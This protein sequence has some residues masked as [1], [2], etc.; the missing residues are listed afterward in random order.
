[1]CSAPGGT[2]ASRLAH[3]GAN[4]R[5]VPSETVASRLAQASRDPWTTTRNQPPPQYRLPQF[6]LSSRQQSI[7]S[8]HAQFVLPVSHHCRPSQSFGQHSQA[9]NHPTMNF[10]HLSQVFNHHSQPFNLQSQTFNHQ[11]PRD[12]LCKQKCAFNHHYQTSYH[13]NQPHDLFYSMSNNYSEAKP[14]MSNSQSCYGYMLSA[15]RGQQHQLAYVNRHA[16]EEHYT[17]HHNKLNRN[18]LDEYLNDHNYEHSLC[19]NRDMY[20]NHALTTT[21]PLCNNVYIERDFTN[22]G[23]NVCQ[24]E[25]RMRSH[26]ECCSLCCRGRSWTSTLRSPSYQNACQIDRQLQT[27]SRQRFTWTGTETSGASSDSDMDTR[28]HRNHSFSDDDRGGHVTNACSGHKMASSSLCQ[29][30]S[31]SSVTDASNHSTFG[32][33]DLPSEVSSYH[34]NV[35]C[36]TV[37]SSP[38]L[39]C[40]ER[41][42]TDSPCVFCSQR[43]PPAVHLRPSCL[44]ERCTS[45]QHKDCIIHHHPTSSLKDSSVRRP[46]CSEHRCFR[47]TERVSL[48][49]LEHHTEQDNYTCSLH[50]SS[51]SRQEE[52]PVPHSSRLRRTENTIGQYC[53]S[54]QGGCTLVGNFNQESVSLQENASSCESVNGLF[55]NEATCATVKGQLGNVHHISCRGELV[56]N[57]SKDDIVAHKRSSSSL[58]SA[59]NSGISALVSNLESVCGDSQSSCNSSYREDFCYANSNLLKCTC[60]NRDHT[61]DGSYQQNNP[62]L[63]YNIPSCHHRFILN[64]KNVELIKSNTSS[65][66]MNTLT[67]AIGVTE[68]LPVVNRGNEVNQQP[69]TKI[70]VKN[71]VNLHPFSY[72]PQRADRTDVVNSPPLTDHHDVRTSQTVVTHDASEQTFTCR[73]CQK[74][75]DKAET[76]MRSVVIYNEPD[77]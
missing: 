27:N 70:P 37:V 15:T 22:C 56:K 49:D 45:R 2:V 32:S 47:S 24:P 6:Q 14:R 12:L 65:S 8:A 3:A 19:I 4:P 9:V 50:L 13:D 23:R 69:F 43:E 76:C 18:A 11:L 52:N 68:H 53:D 28:K 57:P 16:L 33:S 41:Q 55:C 35:Y 73:S 59:R 31:D 30:G 21:S 1:M 7:R 51:N 60:R 67:P 10:N 64:D 20:V 74:T 39:H 26:S 77:G 38:P 72:T 63:T 17:T 29:Y 25:S 5:I 61:D 48:T 36:D 40:D 54:D 66:P 34:S 46:S 42:E 44:S 62:E 75:T 58:G 71:E